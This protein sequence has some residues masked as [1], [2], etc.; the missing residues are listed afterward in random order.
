MKPAW[1]DIPYRGITLVAV[2]AMF[3]AF[4]VATGQEV[5]GPEESRSTHGQPANGIRWHVAG[6]LSQTKPRR[7]RT[8]DACG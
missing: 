1:P 5:R 6:R 4:L 8:C 7:C 2:G 3:G